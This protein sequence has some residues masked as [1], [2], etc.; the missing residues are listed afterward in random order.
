MLIVRTRPATRPDHPRGR[1]TPVIVAWLGGLMALLTGTIAAAQQSAANAAEPASSFTLSGSNRTRYERLAPQYRAGFGGSDTVLALQTN[2]VFTAAR[3][4]WSFVGEI[5][6]A[7][8]EWNDTDS[9]LTGVVNTLEPIQTY[10]SWRLDGA[11]QAGSESALRVGRVTIDLGKRRLLARSNFRHALATF[12]GADWDWRGAAGNRAQVFY[13]APMR[14]EPATTAE[15]LDNEQEL[16]HAARD[17]TVYGAYYLFAP[18]ADRSRLELSFLELDSAGSDAAGPL[19]IDTLALRLFR[20]AA[21]G[22]FNYELE[23]GVQ[24]GDATA[25]ALL[26]THHAYYAHAEIGY[27]FDLPWSPNLLLQYDRASGDADPADDESQRFNPLFGERRFD[28]GPTSIYGP[29][30]RSNIAT[31]G[32]RLTFNPAPQWRGML[33]YRDFR[34]AAKRDAWVGSGLRDS[35]GQS[36]DSLGRQ[37]EG[38]F[39]WTVIPERLSFETGFAYLRSGEFAKQTAGTAFRGDPR[40]FYAAI[41]TSF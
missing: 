21:P 8:A 11:L 16:D 25:G 29:F 36:G 17:T 14:I 18:W 15:L 33:A 30:A 35:T 31:P 23:V 20:P 34:L 12:T 4:R 39:T 24:H 41:T 13:L 19:D 7:R 5:M 10:V 40:Y 1:S 32:L 37:L 26:L 3:G 6:D 2:V 28:T 27:A 9:F 22:G 38:S